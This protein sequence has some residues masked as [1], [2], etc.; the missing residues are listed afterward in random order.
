MYS[1]FQ[2][3]FFLLCTQRYVL[4]ILGG[5]EEK[6]RHT[7]INVKLMRLREKCRL[8]ASC[9]HHDWDQT[10]NPATWGCVLTVSQTCSLL[11]Y[12]RTLHLTEQHNQGDSNSTDLQQVYCLTIY[13]VF[14]WYHQFCHQD[15]LFLIS[16]N[17]T[18]NS[19]PVNC[20]TSIPFFCSH[21]QVCE[22]L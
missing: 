13:Y 16:K 2:V 20:S 12:W 22:F 10:C 15:G 1:R 21:L 4:L 18:R 3:F 7:H 6:G 9:I 11:V 17:K 8:V 5:G 14:S 19:T